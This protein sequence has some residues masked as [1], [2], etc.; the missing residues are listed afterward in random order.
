MSQNND[1]I[2]HIKRSLDQRVRSNPSLSKP[3]RDA[4]RRNTEDR[5]HGGQTLLILAIFTLAVGA[6]PLPFAPV[7]EI[8]FAVSAALALL[9]A[10]HI[11]RAKILDRIGEN[12]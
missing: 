5:V 10:W 11:D 6:Y 1:R 12:S 2:E 9:G 7:K 8:L 4:D 3:L